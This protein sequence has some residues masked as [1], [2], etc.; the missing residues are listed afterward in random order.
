MYYQ[1]DKKAFACVNFI[2]DTLEDLDVE[3][4]SIFTLQKLLY[5]AFG[6]HLRIYEEQ[7]FDEKIQAWQNG[8]VVPSVYRAFKNCGT[9]PVNLQCQRARIVKDFDGNIITPDLTHLD[10]LENLENIQKSLTIACIAYHNKDVWNLF[11]KT[12]RGK[13][14]AWYK[15]YNRLN[16]K[17]L[18]KNDIIEEFRPYLRNLHKQ[19]KREGWF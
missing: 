11:N 3:N 19:A 1:D 16:N 2:L 12:H 5:F 14:S 4:A 8:I 13:T 7:L 15:A 18:D 6:F 9:M 10:N 17:T